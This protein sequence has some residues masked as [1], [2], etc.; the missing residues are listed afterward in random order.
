MKEKNK[1]LIAKTDQDGSYEWLPLWMH[2][3]DTAGVMKKL[4][5]KWVPK[6]TYDFIGLEEEEFKKVAVFIAA[7]H[8]IGKATS[9]FQHLISKTYKDKLYDFENIGFTINEDYTGTDKVP[10]A[11]AG[12]CILLQREIK[13]KFNIDESFANV[14]WSHHGKCDNARLYEPS[15]Q[16]FFGINI[17]KNQDEVHRV[18]IDSWKDIINQA[19]KLADI[20]DI[21]SLPILSL[22]SQVILSGL[23]IVADWIASNTSYFPL[24]PLDDY[25]NE[26]MYDYRIDLGWEAINL[27]G[28]WDCEINMMDEEIFKE[29]FGF[30]P[31]QVQKSMIEVINDVDNPGIFILEAQMGVGKTEAALAACEVLAYKKNKNGIFFG[32]PTQATS[33]GLFPRMVNWTKKVL[34]ESED[35]ASIRLSHGSADFNE[36][37]RNIGF[38]GKGKAYVDNVENEYDDLLSIEVHPWFQGNKKAL[39]ADFVIG[40]VDQFLMAS[41]KRKHFMLRHMGLVGKVV[42]IDEC[43]AYDAY[44]NKYLDRTLEW[45]AA[46]KVPVILLSAT[47]PYKRRKELVDCYVKAYSKFAICTKKIDINYPENWGYTD[48]YP[49]L[50]WSDGCS[51]KQMEI[52]QREVKQ[53]NI[54]VENVNTIEEM[55]SLLDNRL[56]D[57]GCACVIVNT[58]GRAQEIYYEFQKAIENKAIDKFNLLLYHSQ[59]TM[60]NRLAKEKE[61]LKRMGKNSNESD[62]NRLILIGTQVLEQSLDYDADIMVSELCPMDLLLQRMGRL[63]RHERESRP[64]LLEKPCFVILRD[65]EKRYDEGSKNVYGDYLLMRTDKILPNSITIPKN[66]SKLV[67]KVY[68]KDDNLG[69]NDEDYENAKRKYQGLIDDKSVK[70]KNYLLKRPMNKKNL[71]DTLVNMETS[72]EKYAECCVRDISSSIDVLLMKRDEKG[73][74]VFLENNDDSK[75][76]KLSPNDIPDNENARKISMQKIKLPHVLSMDW[77]IDNTIEELEKINKEEL[78]MWQKSSWLKGELILLLDR[79]RQAE[80]NGYTLSYSFERGLEYKK[81]EEYGGESL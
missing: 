36:D 14:V 40:T 9:Y 52:E 73:N 75:N 47:L 31:N 8:D 1:V 66:I 17:L 44:M 70:A 77:N 21:S 2:L 50:T 79:N 13:E 20:K 71:S 46:Y 7:I 22:K 28:G 23:V 61:L 76:V 80:L 57:G 26:D 58:V 27:P 39:L 11:Y 78:P 53:K 32:L 67:Q 74:I 6:D 51:V 81:E 35:N 37:Y 29:R 63:H 18:W 69:L 34:E 54:C 48:S 42:V 60:P 56:K 19:I 45:M 43:H 4:A 25:G 15:G 62:R 68:N 24:I 38:G 59:F 16:G 30:Y 64:K 41:L 3:R 49:L 33:N 72:L 65:N 12:G 10:H 55:I 5:S